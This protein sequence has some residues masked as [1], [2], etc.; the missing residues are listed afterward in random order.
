M[1]SGDP[2]YFE[3]PGDY[4]KTGLPRPLAVAP[5]GRRRPIP[6]SQAESWGVINEERAAEAKDTS[7]CLVCGEWVGRGKVLISMDNVRSGVEIPDLVNDSHLDQMWVAD[8]APMCDRCCKITA[9]HCPKIRDGLNSDR[10]SYKI[11]DYVDRSA[12]IP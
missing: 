12:L 7:L 1:T 4:E 10:P 3:N 9:A 2:V 6:W 5:D 8:Q 11:R